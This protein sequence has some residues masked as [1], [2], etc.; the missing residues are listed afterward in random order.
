[1]LSTE[2]L[3]GDVAGLFER[4]GRYV[5][6]GTNDWRDWRVGQWFYGRFVGASA[7]KTIADDQTDGKRM[8]VVERE[9]C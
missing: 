8:D 7:M 6:L 4:S 2:G 5:Q 3:T 1:M 9:Y